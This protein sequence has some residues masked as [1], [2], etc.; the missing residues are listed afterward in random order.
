[1]TV[2]V[3]RTTAA[4]W[5]CLKQLRLAAL[6]DAPTA[7]CVSHAE[8]AGDDNARWQARAAGT[9]PA[10]FYVAF[11]GEA[12]IGMAAAVAVDDD[13]I[14]LIAMW[15]APGWRGAAARVG[16]RL[17]QAVKDHA[18]ERDVILEVAP[19]NG[20]AVAFYERHG[21]RFQ[22][23]TERL[24]SHP[25]IEVRRMSAAGGSGPG[26]GPAGLTPF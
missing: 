10:T 5:Q 18:G 24:A 20:R 12:A 15:V 19:S 9:G 4:D 11:D 22:A 3:R 14:G 6:L 2:S 17:V 13:R 7:F 21:F 23:H 16:D 25:E 1:M 8:A 26:S